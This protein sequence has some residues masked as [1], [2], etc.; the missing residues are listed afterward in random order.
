MNFKRD[1]P[2]SPVPPF[3]NAGNCDFDDG[4]TNTPERLAYIMNDTGNNCYGSCDPFDAIYNYFVAPSLGRDFQSNNIE[5]HGETDL[6]S[7]GAYVAYLNR[8][9]VQAAIHAPRLPYA[10]CNYNLSHDLVLADRFTNHPQPPA[11][12]IVPNLISQGVKVHIFS[13]LLDFEIPHKGQEL[14]LQNMTWGGSQGFSRLPTSDSFDGAQGREERGLSYYTFTNAGH[15]VAQDSPQPAL[16]W[17]I[18]IVVKGP[19]TAWAWS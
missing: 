18:K 11:Y 16:H 10:R 7:D 3:Y 14:V 2:T 15:R 12:K 4:G 5:E 1:P 8:E 6:Y 13:G 17:L 9:D 19:N